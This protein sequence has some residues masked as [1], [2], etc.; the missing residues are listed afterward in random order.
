MPISFGGAGRRGL[1]CQKLS[2]NSNI[3]TLSKNGDG[4]K[5]KE[6]RMSWAELRSYQISYVE[7]LTPGIQI[8][9]L[10]GDRVFKEILR[11]K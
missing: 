1:F 2:I 7:V 9:T 6:T 5:A 3:K 11:L 10:F 8:A 4:E